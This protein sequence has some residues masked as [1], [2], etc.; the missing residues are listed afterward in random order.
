VRWGLWG[1]ALLGLSV[2][3]VLQCVTVCCSV[4]QC[5]AVC[6]NGL[7]WFCSGFVGIGIFC[8]VSDVGVGG[9]V[10]FVG[11]SRC[12]V[13]CV[14]VCVAAC[15]AVCVVVCVAVCVAVCAG[16]VVLVARLSMMLWGGYV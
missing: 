6:C 16:L 14:A 8:V 7:Q 5:V 9:V 15:V 10:E 2:M 12:V 13:V 3:L 11:A 1:F 4:F